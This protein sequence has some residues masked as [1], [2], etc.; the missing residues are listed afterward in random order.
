[1]A[2]L[3]LLSFAFV[4]AAAGLVL[5]NVNVVGL[6][7]A[8]GWS[9]VL[10]LVTGTNFVLDEATPIVR[11]VGICCVLLCSMKG[12]VY[13]EWAGRHRLS[14]LNYSVF[15]FLWLGMDPGSF[16]NKRQGLSWKADIYLG[17]LLTVVGA[18]LAWL[19][20]RLEWRLV[21]A[22]FLPMSLCF[23]FG[24]LRVSKGILRA[25]GFPVR[26]LFPNLLKAQ[27]LGDF[28]SRR[29]NVGYSQMMQRV[30]GRPV[31]ALAGVHVGLLAVFIVSGL[32]HELAIT[33]PVQSGFGLP[34]AY[35]TVHGILVILERK[36]NRQL[37]TMFTLLAVVLPLGWLFPAAF[38]EEVL[39]ESLNR[40]ASLLSMSFLQ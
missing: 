31:E 25:R 26:T 15:C 1:M 33:L 7:R 19:V 2:F 30:V 17:L 40:F 29:W 36:Y 6:R 28:W 4:G 39:V 37:G 14:L 21:V 35:F 34:T 10:I 9:V 5:V 16:R 18:L 11:M 3:F 23:H 24:V 20:W 22:V 8:L 13:A 32:L 27:G 12:L 38:H